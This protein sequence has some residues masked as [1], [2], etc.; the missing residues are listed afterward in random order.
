MISVC[1]VHWLVLGAV[2]LIS[3]QTEAQTFASGWSELANTKLQTVCPPN[4]PEYEFKSF[5]KNVIL[6]WNGGTVDTRRSRL[7]IWGGGHRDYA[8]NEI[9]ALD[10]GTRTMQRLTDP[11]PPNLPIS[12]PTCPEALA[13]GRPNAR[14]TYGGVAY[15]EHA[16]RLFV[17]G[18]SLACGPGNFGGDTWTFSFTSLTWQR[19]NPSG[20]Q[21][22]YDA[23][24]VAAYDPNSRKVFLHD[25]HDLYAYTFETNSYERLASGNFIDYHMMAAVD[26]VRKRLVIIGGTAS[27][28]GGLMV[29]DIGPGSMY[30]AQRWTGEAAVVNALSPGIAYDPGSD[31]MVVWVGGGTVYSLNMDTQAWTTQTLSGGPGAA[32]ENGTFGRWGYV[33]EA[34]VFVTVTGANVN[35]YALRLNGLPPSL[36]PDPPPAPESLRV[37]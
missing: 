27:N 13:D 12:T 22:R 5:C 19:M 30:N 21:P 36:A 20:P 24:I 9:Y 18:G 17:Y 26:P 6:A 15:I 25:A 7:I 23:G 31:R 3:G 11:S 34:G 10:V 1:L 28:H 2:L 32:P 16:D 14:H 29:Y 8:G 4:S 35:A 37:F 33:P